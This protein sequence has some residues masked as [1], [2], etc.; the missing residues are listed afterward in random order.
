MFMNMKIVVDMDIVTD[1]DTDMGT[2]CTPGMGMNMEL[3]LEWI[4]E[5]GVNAKS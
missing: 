4:S 5:P 3:D 2:N 1:G